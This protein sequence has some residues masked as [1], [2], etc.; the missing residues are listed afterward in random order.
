VL[1]T[2]ITASVKSGLLSVVLCTDASELSR[3]SSVRH[4]YSKSGLKVGTECPRLMYII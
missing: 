4:K 1:Q 3:G 2:F